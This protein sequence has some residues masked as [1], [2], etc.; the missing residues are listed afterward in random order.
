MRQRGSQIRE[1]LEEANCHLVG[2][3]PNGG[4]I[5]FDHDTNKADVYQE[6]DDHA[7]WTL[8]I[9][10]VGHEFVRTATSTDL[11]QLRV[12]WTP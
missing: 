4:V 2:T 5:V 12:C 11:E 7:G 1:T 8:E 10:G 6:H 3:L 9:E